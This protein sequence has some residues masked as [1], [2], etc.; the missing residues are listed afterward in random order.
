MIL[1]KN[2][3]DL[4]YNYFLLKAIAVLNN[5]M[6][7]PWSNGDYSE[8]YSAMSPNN[9]VGSSVVYT[10]KGSDFPEVAIPINSTPAACIPDA[11]PEGFRTFR[12]VV[13]VFVV[14]ILC[15]VG[16]VGNAL[17]VA[18][19]RRDRDKKN[20][21]NWLLQ[22]L[23]VADT[24]Y[25]CAS[26]FVQTLKTINADTNW[27]PDLQR[28]FP[29]L[30]PYIW[31]FASIAQTI[32]V[33]LVML[34]TIDRYIAVC[35]PLKTNMRTLQRTKLAVAIVVIAAILYNVPRFLEREIITKFDSCTNRTILETK[36]TKFRENRVY[37]LVYK[38][39]M[40]FIFRTIGPLLALIILNL[41]LV[42]AL[43][44]V[45][46]KHRD[47]TRS[48]KHRENITLMLVVV[49]TVFILC[50]L[51][52]LI[53]RIVFAF[54]VFAKSGSYN[55]W[56]LRYINVTSNALL[57]LNSGINFLIYCLIGNKFRNI[58]WRMC[59]TRDRAGLSEVSETEP[60]TAKTVIAHNGALKDGKVNNN[61]GGD[62]AV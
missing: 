51:P 54:L 46:K 19:L 21:T 30:E 7:T 25:L 39:I 43:R 11:T 1:S 9:S 6:T 44:E 23:A 48:T 49:V 26:V 60:L 41:R 10:A 58:L 3:S 18:V 20:T 42:K 52:D 29:Y 37:F 36:K 50:E 33:W 61:K 15:L 40:Y 17:S 55:I 57:T 27:W 47:M 38:T 4:S 53:V 22:T 8:I 56:T 14:G 5:K 59:C 12:I 24:L 13:N 62:V 31:P 45:R 16:F 2:L 35:L 34:V 32:T 28:A